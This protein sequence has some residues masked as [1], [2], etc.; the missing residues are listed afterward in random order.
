MYLSKELKPLLL[1]AI[2]QYEQ[3]EGEWG[4]GRSFTQMLD[5]NDVP[6]EITDAIQAVGITTEE[7]LELLRIEDEIRSKSWK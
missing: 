6:Q 2:Q 4:H 3:I 7:L 5:E 1:L